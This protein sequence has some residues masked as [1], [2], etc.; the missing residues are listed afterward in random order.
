MSNKKSRKKYKYENKYFLLFEFLI[1]IFLFGEIS[2]F[3]GSSIE[4]DLFLEL[5]NTISFLFNI[6]IA[7][8]LFK[9]IFD[10]LKELLFKNTSLFL[11]S[12]LLF[13]NSFSL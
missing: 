4:N 5:I 11:C 3:I 10:L 1:M 6:F 12:K 9:D 8:S 13:L 2:S 7:L